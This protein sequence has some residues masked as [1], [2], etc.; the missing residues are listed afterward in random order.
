MPHSQ[1]DSLE[2][3]SQ[4]VHVSSR[5]PLL[6]A[7]QPRLNVGLQVFQPP[8]DL[9]RRFILHFLMHRLPVAADGQVIPSVSNFL[10][11][12]NK[13]LRRAVSRLAVLALSPL[14]AHVL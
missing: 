9:L 5:G 8:D 10:G 12:N 14:L 4:V 3:S 1:P 6:E 7:R 2:R 13:A 11:R